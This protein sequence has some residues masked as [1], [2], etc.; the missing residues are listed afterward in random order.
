MHIAHELKMFQPQIVKPPEVN[1]QT[2]QRVYKAI[3]NGFNMTKGMIMKVTGFSETHVSVAVNQLYALGHLS[4]IHVT[5]R[6]RAY[7]A[8]KPFKGEK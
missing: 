4:M 7:T 3:S 5:N 1:T 2:L 8:I 6:L